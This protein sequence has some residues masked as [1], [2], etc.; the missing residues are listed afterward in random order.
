MSVEQRTAA[1]LTRICHS[2]FEPEPIGL[3][4]TWFVDWQKMPPDL[5]HCMARPKSRKR[6]AQ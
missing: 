3:L 4:N 1:S 5:Q 2:G 6:Y